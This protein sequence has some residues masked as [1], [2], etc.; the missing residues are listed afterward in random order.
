M[1][2]TRFRYRSTDGRNDVNYSNGTCLKL[3]EPE[4]CVYNLAPYWLEIDVKL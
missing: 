4:S 2:T 1:R 3:N